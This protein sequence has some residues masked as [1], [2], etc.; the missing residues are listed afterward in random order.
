MWYSMLIRDFSS[1]LISQFHPNWQS[2][3]RSGVNIKKD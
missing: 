3:R 1:M 2:A